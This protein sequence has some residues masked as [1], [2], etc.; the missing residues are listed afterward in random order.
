MILSIRYQSMAAEPGLDQYIE[1]CLIALGKAAVIKEA[2][3]TIQHLPE[4]ALTYGTEI[5][6]HVPGADFQIQSSAKTPQLS[7]NR[8]M[9]ILEKRMRS[10]AMQRARQV[11]DARMNQPPK[12]PEVLSA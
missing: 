8:A 3:V 5:F 4:D 7:C 9:A 6:V 2:T 10:R 1:D 12:S 11:I